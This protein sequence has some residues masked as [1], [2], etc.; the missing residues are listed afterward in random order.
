M[1]WLV[2][3]AELEELIGAWHTVWRKLQNNLDLTVDFDGRHYTG[4]NGSTQGFAS[5][6]LHHPKTDVS[7]VT[8]FNGDWLA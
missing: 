2:E 6:L 8:L 7:A 1:S 5:S 3:P 4:H